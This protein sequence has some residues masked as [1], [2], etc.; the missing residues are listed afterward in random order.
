[1]RVSPAVRLA[2]LRCVKAAIKRKQ[3]SDVEKGSFGSECGRTP[4]GV[5]FA[6]WLN[7][8]FHGDVLI[9]RIHRGALLTARTSFAPLLL[10]I[11]SLVLS[12]FNLSRAILRAQMRALVNDISRTR[13]ILI[14][15]LWSA[16]NIFK[17][18]LPTES[19][20]LHV[21]VLG[22]RF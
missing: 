7:T 10:C 14:H 3:D 15:A 16:I 17:K 12:Y 9:A 2:L 4:R 13:K 18:Q 6:R 21:P 11:T 19:S 20:S 8:L 22:Y 1:M 5:L